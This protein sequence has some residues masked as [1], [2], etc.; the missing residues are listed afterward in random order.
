MAVS[1]VSEKCDEPKAMFRVHRRAPNWR[2]THTFTLCPAPLNRE[3]SKLGELLQYIEVNGLFGAD[4]FLLYNNSIS[5]KLVPYLD[6]YI[7]QGKVEVL[8]WQMPINVKQGPG[9]EIHYFGQVIAQ[10]ECFYRAMMTSRFVL[11]L[12]MDEVIVPMRNSNWS[13]IIDKHGEAAVYVFRN[14]FFRKEWSQNQKFADHKMMQKY[15]IDALLYTRREK[16][17]WGA[18]ARSKYIAR[19]EMVNMAGIHDAFLLE[20]GARRVTI[21]TSDGLLAHYR[22]WEDY[23]EQPKEDEARMHDFSEAILKRVAFI[24]SVVQNG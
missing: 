11:S 2:P 3:Y 4:H 21:P 6:Y 20:P 16:T 10:S 22:D 14:T 23:R 5:D 1:V 18:G 12:D 9:N 17:I 15:P 19:P 8:N 7:R 13:S 24:D